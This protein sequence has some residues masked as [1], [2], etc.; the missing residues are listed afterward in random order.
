MTPTTHPANR[1]S[2]SVH[3]SEKCPRCTDPKAAD[4]V[5][6]RLCWRSIPKP[7]RRAYFESTP[8]SADRRSKLGACLL[9]IRRPFTKRQL[10]A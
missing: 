9:N 3:G 6:C 2:G 4:A 1:T 8:F 5:V 10:A 7:M